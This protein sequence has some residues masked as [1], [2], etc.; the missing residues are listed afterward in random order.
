MKKEN[1]LVV[2]I[3]CIVIVGVVAYMKSNLPHT[4]NAEVNTEVINAEVNAG[5][6]TAATANTG[7]K[8]NND[9]IEH[10][11]N[12]TAAKSSKAKSSNIDWKPYTQGVNLAKTEKKPMFLY[13]RADWCKYCTKLKNITFVDKDVFNY[14]NNNFISIK[15]DIEKQKNFAMEWGIRGVPNSW[16]LKADNSKISNIPG[17]IAPDQFLN[18]LKYIHTQ[19]YD[20]MSFSDFLKRE[21]K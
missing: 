4:I 8:N 14:L 15:I 17:Y 2:V 12:L 1:I 3:I 5:A 21:I 11:T 19:S 13:F 10:K 16:F 9:A 7:V 20:K 6:N 18:I